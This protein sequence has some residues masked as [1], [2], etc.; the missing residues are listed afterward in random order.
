LKIIFLTGSTLASLI[1]A[2]IILGA[3][4][5]SSIVLAIPQITFNQMM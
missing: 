3:Y 2:V 5:R 1:F 4:F